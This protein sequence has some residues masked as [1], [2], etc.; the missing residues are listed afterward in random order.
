MY[1]EID[2][3]E[4]MRGRTWTMSVSFAGT[5]RD[6]SSYMPCHSIKQSPTTW[7]SGSSVEAPSSA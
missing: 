2:V 5:T 7:L 3:D 4:S 6:S 1:N